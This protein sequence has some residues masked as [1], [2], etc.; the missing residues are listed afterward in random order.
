MTKQRLKIGILLNGYSRPAWS[1][2]IIKQIVDSDYATI[3]LLVV[4]KSESLRTNILKKMWFRWKQLPFHAHLRLDA[5][6]FRKEISYNKPKN[7]S[8]LLSDTEVLE[9]IPH[10]TRHVDRFPE[11]SI[12][13][14]KDKQLDI[15]LRM[16][17]R[18]LKGDIL[19]AAKYGVWSYHHGDNRV[20]RGSPPA[21]WESVQQWPT[22]GA[23]LQ[24]L[25]EE[26]DGGKILYKLSTLT[27]FYSV[28]LNRERLYWATSLV[29][30]RVVKGIYDHG[31]Y[32]FHKL[33]DEYNDPID[34]Y[35]SQLYTVPTPLQAVSGMFKQLTSLL[36]QTYLNSA[37]RHHWQVLFK[38][39]PINELNESIRK[40][41]P[42]KS[43]KGRFWA[44]PFIISNGDT[45]YIFV[46][47]YMYRE[48]KGR[49]A[50]LEA[51]EKGNLLNHEVILEKEYHLSYPFVFQHDGEYYMVPASSSKKSIDLYVSKKFPYKWELKQ[52]LIK[53][54]SAVD[55]TLFYHDN[56]WWMFTTID[57]TPTKA[58]FKELY[59]FYANDLL[60]QD[61]T[62][63]P[64]NPISSMVEKLR[65]AGKVFIH[66]G[67]IIRPSQNSSGSYGRALNFNE[68]IELSKTDFKER[69]ITTVE[70]NWNKRVR[71]V[72]TFN[73]SGNFRVS[74]AFYYRSKFG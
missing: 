37:K 70:P 58:G 14:I 63:H 19:N 8:V 17:F 50:V 5:F 53:G 69:L 12:S 73:F 13:Y 49:L 67:K 35:D 20:N 68:I 51:D 57:D 48:A 1:Y 21:Y 41:K 60:S 72:H 15:I 45:Q 26:L 61:W 9:V 62:P 29:V 74:D 10:K 66:K 33:L 18:I 32:Y 54:L 47:E 34:F 42:I 38:K 6:L 31:D 71:G 30:P 4:N 64:M 24:V 11:E 7:I 39:G 27:N 52:S 59:L 46:E 22:S 36:N 65:P 44:D 56:L 25:N 55:T 23:V 28:A 16:G 2:E 43:P 40:Y 3:E